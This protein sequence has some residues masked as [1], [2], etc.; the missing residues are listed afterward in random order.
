[1]AEDFAMR[2]RQAKALIVSAMRI[3]RDTGYEYRIKPSEVI[4]ALA[5][6]YKQSGSYSAY[7]WLTYAARQVQQDERR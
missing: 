6:L 7:H 5:N 4:F 3:I 1:M 2:R